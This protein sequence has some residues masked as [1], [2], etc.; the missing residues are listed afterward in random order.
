[1]KLA[2]ATGA[3]ALLLSTVGS[4]AADLPVRVDPYVSAPMAAPLWTGFYV[5]LNAG[6]ALNLKNG[7]TYSPVDTGLGG[8]SPA[9]ETAFSDPGSSKNAFTGG[10]QLGYNM[11]F[12]SVVAGVEADINYVD[13]KGGNVSG[14]LFDPAGTYT[15]TFGLVSYDATGRRK[16]DWFGT[17]RGRLGFAFDRALVYATGGLAYGRVAG[18]GQLTTFDAVPAVVSTYNAAGSDRD[19]FGWALGGGIEYAFAQNWSVKAEY[20][21]VHFKDSTY[22]LTDTT[23]VF[24]FAVRQSNKMD[25]VRAGLNY[26]F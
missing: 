24:Q 4:F 6:A 20:L 3:T 11:Q 19:Q 14:A 18:G 26:R 25:L 1:M 13:R 12:G 7:A 22:T 21:H 10:A 15:T 23:G 2:F 9:T 17:V 8:F 5:G 16:S